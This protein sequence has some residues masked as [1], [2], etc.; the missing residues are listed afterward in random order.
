MAKDAARRTFDGLL[1][2]LVA[3]IALL[4]RPLGRHSP[5]VHHAVACRMVD[6]VW[7]HRSVFVTPMAAVAGAVADYVLAAMVSAAPG[8]TRAWVNNGGDIAVY[9]APGTRF[10]VGLVSRPDRP[11]LAG[12]ATI[13][14]EQPIRGIATSGRHG[15]SLSL[16][17][18]DAVTVLAA[19]AAS[20]DV[21]ATL[22]ANATD[23]PGHPAIRRGPANHE[24]PD[25]DLGARPV[26]LDVGPLSA[27]DTESALAAGHATA[28]TMVRDG[29]ICAASICLEDSWE[30]AGMLDSTA[31]LP[32]SNRT[33]L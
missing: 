1:A 10:E 12:R 7:R 28:S 30:F 22:I 18:A 11:V 4:R 3:E 21:A 20:A 31:L 23:L 8:L 2:G 9:L 17:I 14:S 16:G 27:A 6:A 19:D 13:A 29:L 33:R 5:E 25:S 26:V 15:R 24:D 32:P